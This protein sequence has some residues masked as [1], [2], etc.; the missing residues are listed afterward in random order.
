MKLEKALSKVPLLV[1]MAAHKL[2]SVYSV[3]V[4]SAFCFFEGHTHLYFAVVES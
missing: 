1:E 2:D 3:I 4:P